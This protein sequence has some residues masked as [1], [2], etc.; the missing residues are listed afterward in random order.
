MCV[1]SY[2]CTVANHAIY[3]FGSTI[4]MLAISGSRMMGT[5]VRGLIM[6]GGL[7]VILSSN[8]SSKQI[9]LSRMSG[10]QNIAHLWI[11]VSRHIYVCIFI[12]LKVPKRGER[13]ISLRRLQR[14]LISNPCVRCFVPNDALNWIC[15][16]FCVLQLI[17]HLSKDFLLCIRYNGYT[18]FPLA[19]FMN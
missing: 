8:S 15:F 9:F 19:S 16:A 7:K 11:F 13:L 1:Y 4:G 2:T 10:F 5:I 12:L 6:S 14:I 3:T 18:Y 17:L